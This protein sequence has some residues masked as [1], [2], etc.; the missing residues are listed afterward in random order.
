[1]SLEEARRSRDSSERKRTPYLAFLKEKREELLSS[2]PSLS[3]KEAMRVVVAAWN[4]LTPAEKRGYKVQEE[5][6]SPPAVRSRSGGDRTP[7]P[8]KKPLYEQPEEEPPNPLLV[9]GRVLK[10]LASYFLVRP[11]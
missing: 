5:P 11:I 7:Q 3:K 10:A 2:D 1:M 6:L 8:R 9:L 4:D